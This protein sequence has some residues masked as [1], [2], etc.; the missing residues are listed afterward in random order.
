[1]TGTF[2][3]LTNRMEETI[4]ECTNLH[5]TYPAMVFG[6]IFVIR[7]NRQVATIVAGLPSDANV[8]A[9]QLAVNDIR[10]WGCRGVDFSIPFGSTRAYGTPR[11]SQRCQSLR[12]RDSG[13]D[14]ADGGPCGR[15]VGRIASARQ[16]SAVGSVFRDT[17]LR[18][19]ERYLFGAP[20]LKSVTRRLEW[21][22][23][24]PAL[25]TTQIGS[26]LFPVLDYDERTKCPT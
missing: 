23:S 14:R 20:D 13:H 19:V 21:A 8:P 10:R 26:D 17:Y 24:S 1:M 22:P 15:S 7:A 6:Y 11:D 25:D 3:N 2:C 12:G 4:G 16:L 5:I 9:R 18:Y